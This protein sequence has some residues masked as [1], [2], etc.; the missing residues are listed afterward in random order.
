MKTR[1]EID[2]LRL[3]K[4]CQQI[5][6]QKNWR[7]EKYVDALADKLEELRSLNVSRPSRE[8]LEEY[9]RKIQFLRGL[10]DTEKLPSAE[11]RLLAAEL[12]S[13]DKETKETY[14]RTTTKYHNQVREELL[15]TRRKAGY[16]DKDHDDFDDNTTNSITG[17]ILELTTNL[18]ENM[19]LANNIIKK[20]TE[21]L[22]NATSNAEANSF[23]IKTNI[24]R[25][26]DF[27]RTG[28]QCKLWAAIVLVTCTFLMMVIFIRLFPKNLK[29]MVKDSSNDINYSKINR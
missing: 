20:D 21:T 7:L 12:L 1:N 11:K 15:M 10:I 16:K 17:N 8:T 6:D 19:F 25:L 18:K 22:S 5:A 28:C 3:L 27:L 23:R 29:D 26:G 2:F 14:L 24:D 4:Q 9:N 13:P